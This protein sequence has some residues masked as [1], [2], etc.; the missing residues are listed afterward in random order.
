MWMW[1]PG[2]WR[3]LF[4]WGKWM[5]KGMWIEIDTNQNGQLDFVI[6]LDYTMESCGI[7]ENYWCLRYSNLVYMECSLIIWIF[8]KASQVVLM[9]SKASLR[10][11][12]LKVYPLLGHPQNMKDWGGGAETKK[13]V[14]PKE[15]TNLP[16]FLIAGQVQLSP[17]TPHYSPPPQSSPAPTPIPSPFGFVHA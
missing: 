11:I 2:F 1:S 5:V 6:N 13:T 14:P 12:D 10:A 8:F 15:Y 9:Y 3:N 16:L 4:S 7:F 17:C